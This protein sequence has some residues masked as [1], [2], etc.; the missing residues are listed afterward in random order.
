[1]QLKDGTIVPLTPRFRQGIMS[2]VEGMA[3]QGLRVLACAFKSDLGTLSDYNGPNHPGHQTL[4]NADN[5][6]SIESGATFVG[7]GGLQVCDPI[8]TRPVCFYHD[9]YD[10][11][12]Q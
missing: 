7:L 9:L 12:K 2:S 5:Y 4:I 11:T 1:M 10:L 3:C 6:S 8:K